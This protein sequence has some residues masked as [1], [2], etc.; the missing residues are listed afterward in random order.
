MKLAL[1]FQQ[2]SSRR[3]WAGLKRLDAELAAQAR[4]WLQ[5]DEAW[6]VAE[7]LALDKLREIHKTVRAQCGAE[8]KTLGLMLARIGS[9]KGRWNAYAQASTWEG[10]WEDSRT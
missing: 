2:G 5:Q 8:I 6:T 3:D 1:A 4:A 10:A 9:Q 7:Q